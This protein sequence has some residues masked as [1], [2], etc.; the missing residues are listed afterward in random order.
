MFV[1]NMFNCCDALIKYSLINFVLKDWNERSPHDTKL[2]CGTNNNGR[3]DRVQRDF[4]GCAQI[5]ISSY[6]FDGAC[7][8]YIL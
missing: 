2:K 5:A 3:A 4:G 6:K 8:K 7:V 1:L